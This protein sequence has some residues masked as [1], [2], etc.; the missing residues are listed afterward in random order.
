MANVALL[1]LTFREDTMFYFYDGELPV[2]KG[3]LVIDDENQGLV[4]RAYALGYRL[5]PSTEEEISPDALQRR[6]DSGSFDEAE[7][8]AAPA[9]PDD[10]AAEDADEANAAEDD[11][12][13][14]DAG[15]DASASD[16][17]EADAADDAAPADDAAAD[18]D[19]DAPAD[20]AAADTDA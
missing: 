14:E 4:R 19:A 10:D 6:L 8:P 20:E 18:A 2:N 5:D 11:A 1:H 16:G 3:V 13:N 12:E 7:A 15:E 17:A 9:A